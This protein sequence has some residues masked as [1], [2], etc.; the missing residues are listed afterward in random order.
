MND[1]YQVL[2]VPRTA[3]EEE[4]K[5]AYRELARR[6]HPDNYHGSPLADL[7]QE[8]MK[9]INAAYGQVQKERGRGR[10][11]GTEAQSQYSGG[12]GSY[13]PYS[14]G[15]SALQQVR[16]AIRMGDLNRA[17]MLLASCG[18]RS[19]EWNYLRGLVYYR[20]GWMDDAKRHYQAA[21]QMDPENQEYRQALEFMKQANR[22]TY[23]PNGGSFGTD[24][25]LM[26]PCSQFCCLWMTCGCCEGL[27]CCLFP[28][29]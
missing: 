23:R 14:Y 24:A 9:E 7:A 27:Q 13:G 2:G 4:I 16:M 26:G 18:E 17:E 12:S 11:G 15:G 1:P 10:S 22:T 5:K 20:R 28:F 19:A 8:K 25:C 3:T 6:Y 29:H 21:C